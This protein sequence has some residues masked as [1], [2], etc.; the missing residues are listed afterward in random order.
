MVVAESEAAARDG[1]ALMAVTYAELPAVMSI[2]DAI[3]AGSFYEVRR[4][5]GCRA[6]ALWRQETC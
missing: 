4:R 6:S 2:D 5:A 3:A 1:A